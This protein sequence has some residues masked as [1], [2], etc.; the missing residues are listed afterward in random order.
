[1]KIGIITYYLNV[2]GVE[3]VMLSLGRELKSRGFDVTYVETVHK[4]DW[5]DYFRNS[6]MSVVTIPI[7]KLFS[8]THHVKKI[9]VELNKYDFLIINDAPYAV[10]ALGLLRPEVI[11]VTVLHNPIEGMVL[12][13]LGFLN[14]VN[15]AI[16][17]T[18]SLCSMLRKKEE[19]DG[20]I[21]HIANG[22]EV[23]NKLKTIEEKN[24][25]KILFL[26]R[27]EHKQKGV[28]HLPEIFEKVYSSDKYVTLTVVGDGPDLNELKQLVKNR[29]FSSSIFFKG[30]LDREQVIKELENHGILLMPSYYEG[31]PITL[32]EAMS[33]GV[34]PVVSKIIGHTDVIV[35]HNQNGLLCEI[36]AVEEFAI[37]CLKLVT[38]NTLYKSLSTEAQSD[39]LNKFSIQKMADS[40]LGLYQNQTKS[41]VRTNTID[42]RLL[43]GYVDIPFLLIRP[44]RKIWTIFNIK[45]VQ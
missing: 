43:N 12:N 40:Y 34:V 41:T 36:G 7:N 5:S 30:S 17:I 33:E 14:Q 4:G 19:R 6:G 15:F 16:G 13:A 45:S 21:K 20:I 8:K 27:I 3:S 9:A 10:S 11:S 18:Y 38:N 44:F 32:L 24:I 25:K 28:L 23:S 22:V 42:R 31:H 26:G 29:D 39:M 2:G 1:M 37:N 35:N